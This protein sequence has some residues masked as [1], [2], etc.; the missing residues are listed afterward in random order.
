MSKLIGTSPNQVPSNADLG[1]A[2]FT[3]TNDYLK[4]TGGSL[5]AIKR[6]I[7]KTATS[8]L[9]Y[10]T[11][12]DSDG[13]AWRKRTQGTTWYT[14]K[15]NTAIRG[16]RREFPCV[17]VIVAEGDKVTI[18]DGDD[19]ALSMWMV[20][21]TTSGSMLRSGSISS[22]AA[23]N[24]ELW[25]GHDAGSALHEVNFIKDNARWIT[26]SSAYG[27]FFQGGGIENRN[28][29]G[30]NYYNNVSGAAPE[31]V[32]ISGSNIKD[33]DICVQKGAKI[34]PE[35]GLHMT[36]VA[37]ATTTG[38]S[39]IRD[40]NDVVDI[41]GSAGSNYDLANTIKI[42]EHEYLLFD[43]D[44]SRRAAFYIPIPTKNRTTSTN[45]GAITDKL[46]FYGLQSGTAFPK[47]RGLV[48]ILVP[49]SDHHYIGGDTDDGLSI[50]A[51]NYDDPARG[52]A[53]YVGTDHNT[54]WMH[55]SIRTALLC[56]TDP[57]YI[58]SP[59]FVTNG[60]FNSNV[61]GWSTTTGASITWNSDGTATST[62]SGSSIWSGAF[63][64]ISGLVPGRRYIV[65][66]D[67]I[68][69]NNWGSFSVSNGGGSA[70]KYGAYTSWNGGTTFPLKARAEF[71]AT[72]SS[73]VVTVD[74]LNTN[75]ATVTKFDNVQFR[76]AVEDRSTQNRG[77]Q[78]FGVVNRTPVAQGAE[79]V[80]YSG[81]SQ[82]NYIRKPYDTNL[83]FSTSR[84]SVMFWAKKPGTGGGV[85]VQHGPSDL[86]ES[87]MVYFNGN[88]GIYFD[89]GL[90]S[91]YSQLNTAADKDFVLNDEWIHVVCHVEAGGAPGIYINGN[92]VTTSVVAPAPSTFTFDLNYAL[93]IGNGRG[94]DFNIPF[95]GSLAL[96]RVSGSIPS[97]EQIKKIYADEKE[98]FRKNAKC[99]LEGSSMQINAIAYDKMTQL[100]HIGTSGGRSVFSGLRRVESVK[101]GVSNSI[102]AVNGMVVED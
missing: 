26:G 36:T 5:K 44:T 47:Y 11:R 76:E 58:V 81:F 15:L 55:G 59:E 91:Q 83:D 9:V 40:V 62:S 60:T 71:T 28:R 98:L 72:T 94:T 95:D 46:Y 90:G 20:F 13:G 97:E 70:L 75:S 96:V 16:A 21:D 64:G 67:I 63:Q 52:M 23:M 73:V 50:M 30:D 34:N 74:S 51:P 41:S 39:I 66:A 31:G 25:V 4:T 37:I 1:T 78:I 12:L 3:D 33:L 29:V 49:G 53:A 42:D 38:V 56:D 77:A 69:S 14:E 101:Q 92:K 85:A 99:T 43:Q 82:Y 45:S 7:E 79:L 57:R 27:G 22:I 68:S 61:S 65:T 19:D 8:V 48:N 24:G 84:Y 18:Y 32:V 93:N 87:I 86:N 100:A 88:Y 35:T 80:G 89:Y 10:D 2:A 17:A 54:G 102:S 6:T